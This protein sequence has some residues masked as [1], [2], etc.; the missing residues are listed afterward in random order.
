MWNDCVETYSGWCK[1]QLVAV[2][3]LD[4]FITRSKTYKYSDSLFA[5]HF[6]S[7]NCIIQCLFY[8]KEEMKLRH[9]S[10]KKGRWS[11]I[12]SAVH[13]NHLNTP[14]SKICNVFVLVAICISHIHTFPK[15]NSLMLFFVYNLL[16]V[17]LI[18]V[19]IA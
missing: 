1:I 17:N 16:C 19:N 12:A 13:T 15:L 5:R 9:R 3:C 7:Y 2:L 10:R 4:F 8:C 11:S 18:H 14:L 6:I